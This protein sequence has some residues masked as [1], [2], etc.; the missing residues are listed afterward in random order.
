MNQQRLAG[1]QAAALEGVVPDREIGLRN[2]GGF[3]GGEA[4][5]QRK[6]VAFVRGAIFRIA[7]ADHERHHRVAELPLLHAFAERHDRSGNFEPR[8][9]GGALGRRIEALALHHVRSIDA[10]GSDLHQ[11]LA[12]GRPRQCAP[13]GHEHVRPARCADRDHG[14]LAGQRRHRKTVGLT[15]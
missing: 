3:D 5:R 11:H 9:I 2:R 4:R 14:H 13:L 10:R 12:L 15:D 7:A 6:R 1:A 8:D